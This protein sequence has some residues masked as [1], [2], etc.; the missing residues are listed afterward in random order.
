MNVSL[1]EFESLEGLEIDETWRIFNAIIFLLGLFI[2]SVFYWGMIYYEKYGGDPMKRSLQNK[3]VTIIAISI[4]LD[5][6]IFRTAAEWRIHIGTLNDE[7]T[8]VVMIVF[9]VSRVLFSMGICEILIYKVLAINKWSYICSLDEDFWSKFILHFN[10]GFSLITQLS[11]WMF[12]SMNNSAYFHF[13]GSYLNMFPKTQRLFWPIFVCIIMIIAISGGIIIIFQKIRY[14]NVV[15]PIPLNPNNPNFNIM[16]VN[17]PIFSTSFTFVMLG[18]FSILYLL[19]INNFLVTALQISTITFMLI[20]IILP[21]MVVS[22]K[23]NIQKFFLKEM[24]DFFVKC[25]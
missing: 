9:N 5:C 11:R 23:T 2:G 6:Y 13:E 3:L 25:K 1:I 19:L 17:K 7:M 20:Y 24:K 14:N 21:I 22:I 12:G 4:I 16:S 8:M 18:S 10:V 15:N